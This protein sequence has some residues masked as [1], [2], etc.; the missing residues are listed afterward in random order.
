[1]AAVNDVLGYAGRRVIVAGAASDVGLATIK[2]LVDNGAEVHAIDV[3]RPDQPGLA[4]FTETD[5]HD[6]AQVDAA[7]RKIG[8][9]VNALF[10]CV[11]SS[12]YVTERVVPLM[13]EGAAIAS[14]RPPGSAEPFAP[15]FVGE[16]ADNGIRINGVTTPSGHT[17]EDH[18]W[19]L[20]FLNSHR[21]AHVT[22]AVLCPA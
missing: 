6:T 2:I 21:L 4:S 13:I 9:V 16:L 11:E 1:V 7:V 10:N 20:V 15:E 22:G 8:S 5:L 3:T 19:L 18:A 12:E 17:P 14:V